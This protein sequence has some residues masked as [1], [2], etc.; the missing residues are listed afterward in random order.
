[1]ENLNGIVSLLIACIELGF[2]VN[3]LIFAE[4]NY[5]NKLVITLIGFLF[6]YQLI[7]FLICFV[8]LQSSVFVYVAFLD[9]SFLSPLGLLVVLRF[10]N[11]KSKFIYLIFIPALFFALYYPLVLNQL[12][13]TKCTILY[14]GY[15]NPLGFLYG[16]FYYLPILASVI[17]LITKLFKRN[18]TQKKKLNRILLVGY[19]GTF[20]PE[21]ILI[22]IFPYMLFVVESVLCKLAFILAVSYTYFALK[23]KTQ[24]DRQ[25]NV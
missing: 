14:A 2:I 22:L 10:N 18:N 21:L 23:N 7:E 24:P 4:K 19:I 1:M 13:V 5:L 17:I 3:L 25:K 12:E 15:K 16:M 8:E 20:V 11:I 6:G 9:V